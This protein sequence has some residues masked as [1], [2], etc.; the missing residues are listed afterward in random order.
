MVVGT[1]VVGG[2]V[3]VDI[4]GMEHLC[5]VGVA[6][7]MKVDRQNDILDYKE[8]VCWVWV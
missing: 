8:K 2:T 5:G 6:D 4:V 3:V 1:E 7:Y